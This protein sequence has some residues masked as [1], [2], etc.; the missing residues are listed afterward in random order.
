MLELE[1]Y[2]KQFR[3]HTIGTDLISPN[4]HQ[5]VYADW[6]ASGK[7][8]QPIESFI[9]TQLGPYVANTHTH[10]SLTGS[11]MTLA[12]EEARATIKKHVNA[13]EQDMLIAGGSG[14]TSLINKLQRLMGLRNH[15]AKKQTS[16]SENDKPLVLVTH[17]EHHSNH[18]S[19]NECDVT[20]EIIPPNEQG[21]PCLNQLALLLDKYQDRTLKIGS[22]TACSNVTGIFTPYREMAKLLH[23]A[24]GYCFVDFAASAPYVDIDM[25]P[26]DDKLAYLDAVFISAHKFLGGPGACGIMVFNQSLCVHDIPDNPGGGTVDWTTPWGEQRYV[27][28]I[29]SREDG[30]TP[31]FLQMIKA[32]LAIK[33]KEQ[34]STEKIHIRELS[35]ANY[36]YSALVEHNNVV[37]LEPKSRSRLSMISF[38]I[39]DLHHN[40]VV[41]LLCD[42]FGIQA[43]GGCACAGT[44]GHYLLGIDKAQSK[45]ITDKIDAGEAASKPGWVRISLHPINTDREIKFVV[46]A[47][48]DIA[49]H[50]KTWQYDYICDTETGEFASYRGDVAPVSLSSFSALMKPKPT[51][52]KAIFQRL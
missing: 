19:W 30:G 3:T 47:I 8:Y 11:T 34:M 1:S 16:T 44:Y 41:K 4:G 21:T 29:E 26:K 33:L 46:K 42:R 2:F 51:F 28:N 50:G 52:W 43:R 14:V 24:G 31:P 18:T 13:S 32:A 15:S 12:Y 10:T 27:K 36:I 9:T 49:K 20:V 40:L 38:Y 23:R 17:M 5:V 6:T 39:P 7:L 22:F 37:V 45:V 48:K 35:I 25:H